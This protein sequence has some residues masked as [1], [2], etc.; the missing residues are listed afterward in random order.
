MV[1]LKIIHTLLDQSDL[2]IILRHN[3]QWQ[4]LFSYIFR[5]QRI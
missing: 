4:S 5:L 2:Q 1:H 3:K